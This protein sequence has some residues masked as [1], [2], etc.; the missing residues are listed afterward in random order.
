MQLRF[1]FL[2]GACAAAA[3][4]AQSASAQLIVGGTSTST[5]NPAAVYVDVTTGVQ[6]TLW[7]SAAQKKVNGAAANIAG[8]RLYT[9]DAARLNFWDFGSIGTAPTFIAGMYRTTDNVAFTA[10]GVDALAW[11]NGKLYGATSAGSTVFK[12]GIYEVSTVSDGMPTP[13]CVMTPLWNDPTAATTGTSGVLAFEGLDFDPGINKFIATQTEPAS[14]T[15]PDV[16][17]GLYSIDA[18]GTGALV[19]LADF[20]VGVGANIDGL[21][22]GGGRYWLTEY[23]VG[24]GLKIYPYNT[25]TALYESTI[26]VAFATEASQRTAGATWAPGAIPEPTSLAAIGAAAITLLRRRR[27]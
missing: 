12:K 26:T 17:P 25:A 4:S 7:N 8:A 14:A 10:T 13:H 18:F 23:V 15:L 3:V 11:A 1:S 19:K 20:P 2:L 22:V 16:G 9:N 27:V 5:S 21:A 24:T 6:T